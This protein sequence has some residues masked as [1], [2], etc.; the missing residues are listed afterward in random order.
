M[1]PKFDS[2]CLYMNKEFAPNTDSN[3]HL[4]KLKTYCNKIKPFVSH[5][6]NLIKS[7]N[8]TVYNILE[9][10]IKLLLPRIS[11]QKHGIVTTLVSGFIGLAYEGI[12]SFLQGKCD[13]SLKKAV[14]AMDNEVNIQH[15]KLL[16][17]DNTMLMYG[18]YNAETFEKLIN[19][20]HEI[21]NVTSSHKKL[22]AGEHNPAIFRLL[23]TNAL[24]VQQYVFNS[25]LF[26]RVVQDKYISL[27][28]ELIAQLRSYVSA[29]RILA[30]GYLPTTLITP[31][32]LEGILSEV[33]TSLQ[34]TNPDYTLVFER[35]H[36]YYDMQLVTF[37]FD[38]NMNLVIQFPVFIQPYIQKPLVLYQLETVPVPVLETN[39]EAQLYTNLH[40]NKP[41][42]ALN[43]E[44]Y[45]SLT[46][47]ELRSCKMIGRKF[48]CEE[49]FVVKHKSSYSC[50]SAIYFNLTTDIIRD[51]CNFDFDYNKTDITPT[52]LD[53]GDEIILAN[54]PNDKHIVCNINND[55]PVIVPSHPY[56]L[57]D[58]SILC[59]CGLEA[60]NHHLLESLAAC[61]NNHTKLTMYFTINLAFTN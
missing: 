34:H 31:S 46:N 17:L 36:L 3:K 18:I 28:R 47:Q 5:Y 1:Q 43:Q 33:K 45:I 50:E 4:I 2:S 11:R 48:Y 24:G 55:I 53:G 22:F 57:V 19:T 26:L 15:N 23:Y 30:K 7:Y 13:N 21:H 20:V 37:G 51:N 41:Y 25:L 59:N 14:L 40:V 38:G 9:N 35:L 56:V 54:W 60:D 49:L 32:K 27:Y 52:I 10:K 42:L 39:T 58:R 12:S 61:N 44:T 8:N 16:K 6:S 29:I